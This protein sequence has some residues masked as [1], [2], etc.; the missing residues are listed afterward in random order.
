M[1]PVHYP[2]V[3]KPAEEKGSKAK[4]NTEKKERLSK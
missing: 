4:Y 3:A 2:V 1:E